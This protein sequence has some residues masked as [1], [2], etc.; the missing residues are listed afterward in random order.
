[1]ASI[2]DACD[3]LLLFLISEPLIGSAAIDK[4]LEGDSR[5]LDLVDLSCVPDCR[6]LE[7][8][9]GFSELKLTSE[10]LPVEIGFISEGWPILLLFDEFYFAF[11]FLFS[12]I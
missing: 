12:S 8:R 3:F 5:V 1:M 6:T 2:Y 9:I 4:L 11:L 10:A 7:L